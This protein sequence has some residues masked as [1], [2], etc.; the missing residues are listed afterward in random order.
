M[1]TEIT[2]SSPLHKAPGPAELQSPQEMQKEP[3]RLTHTGKRGRTTWGTP[4]RRWRLWNKM[5][6]LGEKQP[7][8]GAQQGS[9]GT[10][11]LRSSGRNLLVSC[12]R[13]CLDFYL[14]SCCKLDPAKWFIWVEKGERRGG[15]PVVFNSFVSHG[16]KS[17]EDHKGSTM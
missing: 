10:T 12:S 4:T 3:Y 11:V 6:T 16:F 14:E 15:Y 8:P 7:L 9:V 13:I 5:K 1:E 17:W 2:M